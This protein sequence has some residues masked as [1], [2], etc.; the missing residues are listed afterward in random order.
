MGFSQHSA[1]TCARS[2]DGQGP[3]VNSAGSF[4]FSSL[5]KTILLIMPTGADSVSRDHWRLARSGAMLVRAHWRIRLSVGPKKNKTGILNNASHS[6][7]A[8][9]VMP[10]AGT[11]HS[12]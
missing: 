8:H 4:C 5:Y 3:A 7:F 12:A 6:I 1:V 10:I 9:A 2:L 11:G